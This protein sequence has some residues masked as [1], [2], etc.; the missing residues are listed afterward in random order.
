MSETQQ[1]GEEQ[2]GLEGV[3]DILKEAVEGG[4][5]GQGTALLDGTRADGSG[6][7]GLLATLHGLS[8]EQASL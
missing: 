2:N 4:V 6:N 8:A 1:N 3:L 7:H 5:P